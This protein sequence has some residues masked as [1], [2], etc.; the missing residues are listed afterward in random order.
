MIARVHSVSLQDAQPGMVL[1]A[2]VQDSA[3]NDLLAEGT[4]LTAA[5]LASLLR[6]GVASV[7]V[8]AEERLSETE[9]AS[10]RKM[11]AERLDFLFRNARG[12]ALMENLHD[13]V[14]Q[15]RLEQLR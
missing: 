13:A 7:Q 8:V 9:L 5:L 12:D 1:A 4:E 14:L 3:G 2:P 15:Y 10:R 6:R 11:V